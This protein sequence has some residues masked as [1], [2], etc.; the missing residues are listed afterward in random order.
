MLRFTTALRR[1]G[2][3]S[4]RSS[5]NK[6]SI[7]S[8]NNNNNNGTSS[9]TASK[10]IFDRYADRIT[11]KARKEG[12]GVG[13]LIDRTIPR[14]EV[15][16]VRNVERKVASWRSTYSRSKGTSVF[17]R[18]PWLAD[19]KREGSSLSEGEG[20]LSSDIEGSLSSD[21]KGSL[22]SDIDRKSK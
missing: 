4:T 7:S 12:V 3:T 17:V 11:H 18:I 6:R 20:G 10:Q 13:Q 8:S 5:R 15:Q 9:N 1:V 2:A 21:I 16:Q 22:S 19:K 14:D